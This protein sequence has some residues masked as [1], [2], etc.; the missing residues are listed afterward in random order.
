MGRCEVEE[1]QPPQLGQVMRE[2]RLRL[3]HGA[4]RHAERLLGARAC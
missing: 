1:A 4:H 3:T 2:Q